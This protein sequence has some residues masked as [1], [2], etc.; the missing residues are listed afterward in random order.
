MD[1]TI[2]YEMA[3]TLGVEKLLTYL[4][5]FYPELDLYSIS[6]DWADDR[7][8]IAKCRGSKGDLIISWA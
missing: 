6:T 3:K 2:D 7:Q 4:E 5:D 1:I 8:Y